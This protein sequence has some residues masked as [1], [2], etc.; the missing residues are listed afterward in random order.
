MQIVIEDGKPIVRLRKGEE[1]SLREAQ[2]ISAELSSWLED[3]EAE[4]A[5]AHLLAVIER[6]VPAE[7]INEPST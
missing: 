5:A 4:S 7:V 2:R 6:Y 1:K 3:E